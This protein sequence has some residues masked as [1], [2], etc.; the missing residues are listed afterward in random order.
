[1]SRCNLKFVSI[2]IILLIVIMFLSSVIFASNQQ[3]RKIVVFE[4][5]LSY[6]Q[7]DELLKKH[8]AE[9]LKNLPGINAVVINV[10]KNNNLKNE[11]GI[12]YIEDDIILSINE[13]PTITPTPAS[14]PASTPNTQLMPW[15]ISYMEAPKFW[16]TIN[17]DKV[18]VGIIDTGIDI[19]HPDLFNN[20]KGGFNVVK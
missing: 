19:D 11:D 12:N 18:K 17:T 13:K 5:N 14:T 2:T 1:M 15:G 10:S 16:G 8:G 7:Q 20:I 4:K 3:E 9:K 6:L